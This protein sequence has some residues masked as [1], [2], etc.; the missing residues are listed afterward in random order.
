M[1]A[2]AAIVNSKNYQN[3]NNGQNQ[4]SS[5]KLNSSSNSNEQGE[6]NDKNEKKYKFL[7]YTKKLPRWLR[8][9]PS[10]SF[11]RAKSL[12]MEIVELSPTMY[13]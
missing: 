4:N 9:T 3:Y 12:G 11:L 7:N 2:L 8:K 13:E 5:S 10:G 1:L 6:S